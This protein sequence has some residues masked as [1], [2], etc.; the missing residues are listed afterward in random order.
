MGFLLPIAWRN[1]WRNP[2]R[3]II[4]LAVV[5]VGMWSILIFSVVLQA[6]VQ[7]SHDN[8]LKLLTGE[9]QI[10]AAGYLDDPNVGRRM[11][12]PAGA[13]A[14]T[15]ASPPISAWTARVRVPAVVESEYR[16]R[17]VTLM[18]VSPQSE[19]AMSYLPSKI[20]E[21]RYLRI[22]NDGGIVI[23][24]DLALRLKTRLGKRIV[25]MAQSAD[26]ELA[27]AGFTIVGIYM[28]TKPA[29]DEFVFTGIRTSQALLGIGDDISEISFNGV[30]GAPPAQTAALVKRA[31][32]KL[33]VQPWTTLLPLAYF[34]E[35]YSDTYTGIWLL[36]MFVL[37]AIGIVNT[38][39]M[40]VFERTHEFGLLQALGMRPRQILIEVT[41]E[42]AL[43]IGLGIVVGIVLT[44][45]TLVPFRNGWDLGGMAR[46]MDIYGLG[47]VLYPKLDPASVLRSA[48]IVWLLGIIAALW[49]ARTAT[50]ANPAAAMAEA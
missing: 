49:P 14:K 23:G 44:A 22:G 28:A 29:E 4:T 8:N 13:L 40:A 38:Q 27:D 11:P 15:L 37:M 1:V 26:G 36:V 42:S 39:L 35:S 19:R 24:R 47:D 45:I 34:M 17:A 50:R 25:L 21:G 3:T 7:S 16:T 33:D 6:F 9:G 12:P 48:L 46:A 32:P 31:A 18:G 2:R 5:A 20:V 10:H 41:I 43:L 30:E